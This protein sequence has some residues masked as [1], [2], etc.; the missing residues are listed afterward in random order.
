LD[1]LAVP[2]HEEL[3][4]ILEKERTIAVPEPVTFIQLAGMEL[5]GKRGAV[6]G[7]AEALAH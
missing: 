7:N 3:S 5:A 2:G 4:A 1:V 6:G